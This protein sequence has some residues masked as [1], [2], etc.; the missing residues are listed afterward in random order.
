MIT[1]FQEKLFW[2][3]LKKAD[4]ATIPGIGTITPIDPTVAVPPDQTLWEKRIAKLQAI[5]LLLKY[6]IVSS[7]DPD[8]Q[9]LKTYL[10][11]NWKTFIKE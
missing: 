5:D 6:N 8:I 9:A 2:M 4:S 3:S 10:Q 7:T 11:N 1:L